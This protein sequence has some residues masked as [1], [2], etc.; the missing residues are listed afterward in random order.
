M[1]VFTIFINLQPLKQCHHKPMGLYGSGVPHQN[2]LKSAPLIG[3]RWHRSNGKMLISFVKMSFTD[4]SRVTLI[5]QY[6]TVAQGN[7]NFDKIDITLRLIISK[8]AQNRCTEV[9]LYYIFMQQIM[10][11]VICL[12]NIPKTFKISH[13][14]M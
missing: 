13:K 7:V 8:P 14:D 4:P 6:Y 12:K 3:M 1:F 2:R 5:Y 10:F 11:L 9:I